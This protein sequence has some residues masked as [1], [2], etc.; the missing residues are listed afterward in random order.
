MVGP[1][2]SKRAAAERLLRRGRSPDVVAAAIAGA[3]EHNRGIVPVGIESA[4]AYRVLR[5]A[6][7]AVRGLLSR[8][9]TP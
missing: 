1:V 5:F 3:V 7:P 9:Q 6:P 2:A 4:V 8:L